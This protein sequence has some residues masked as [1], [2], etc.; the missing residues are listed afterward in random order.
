MSFP[1]HPPS[2]M[3]FSQYQAG[4][5]VCPSSRATMLL[6]SFTTRSWTS[7]RNF[8]LNLGCRGRLSSHRSDT[9]SCDL[10]PIKQQRNIELKTQQRK[11]RRSTTSMQLKTKSS[12]NQRTQGLT[13]FSNV[14]T[15]T[16]R[17]GEIFIENREENRIVTRR[18]LSHNSQW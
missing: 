6:A 16:G 11:R 1:H 5:C 15:S 3:A 18:S 17:R 13:W 8:H 2:L 7:C 14:P 12:H 9:N 10:S 4:P